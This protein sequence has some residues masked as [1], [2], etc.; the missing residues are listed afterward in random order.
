MILYLCRFHVWREFMSF[1]VAGGWRD[2]FHE[3]LERAAAASVGHAKNRVSAPGLP[4]IHSFCGAISGGGS[5]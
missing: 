1:L 5:W 3:E 4:P 2:V